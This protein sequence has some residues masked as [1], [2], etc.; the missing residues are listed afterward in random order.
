MRLI[1]FRLFVSFRV[2]QLFVS[3]LST[4]LCSQDRPRCLK[5]PS[6]GNEGSYP[7]SYEHADI[8]YVRCQRPGAEVGGR[9]YDGMKFLLIPILPSLALRCFFIVS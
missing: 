5:S 4:D 1:L 3:L 7:G 2:L 9:R 8:S 6:S